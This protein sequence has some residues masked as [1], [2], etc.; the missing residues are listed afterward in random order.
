MTWR[1]LPPLNALRAFEAAARHL[2]VSRAAE[3][4]GVTPGAVSRQ[5]HTLEAHVG[6]SLFA[7]H[8][9]GLSLTP[10]GESLAAS[11][12]DALDRIAD[13]ASG[14]RL[15]R[16]R[17]LTIGA[18]G[19]FTSRI[20]LPLLSDL[21]ATHPDLVVDVHTSSNPLD[22]VPGRYD[23]VIAVS[24][25]GPRA[26]LVTHQ[27]M[28]I[29]T[30]PVCAPGWLARGEPDFSKVP[31]LHARPRP[32]DWR[33]WLNYA[34]LSS[35]PVPGGSSFESISLAVEAAAAGFG[36]AIAI[37]GLL[38]PDLAKG[39]VVIA[40]K[41]VRPT[42]RYFVLQYESRFADDQSLAALAAWLEG[43]IGGPQPKRSPR[44]RRA[45]AA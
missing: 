14:M 45:P 24:E 35:V 20:L 15:R 16:L 39:G 33:R 21:R 9:T 26:G 12:R 27:L 17:P 13:A 7:R 22:L 5:V 3:E 37:E 31:L 19:Y 28:P 25:A 34:R 1:R 4:L 18:Y 6:Q 11:A 38:G 30:V 43:R 29:A 23:A 32:D 36:F 40:H 10:A 41:V 2:S 8:S 44:R 42:R